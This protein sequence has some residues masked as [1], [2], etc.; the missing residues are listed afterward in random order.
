MELTF[1]PRGVLQI[2][3]ARI[4]Y[5]NFRGEAS[6]FTREGDRR[7]SLVIPDREMSEALKAEGWN[8]KEKEFEDG[9]YFAHLPVKVNINDRGPS[10]YL[11]SGNSKPVR[12]DEHTVGIIDEIDILSVNLDIRPFD[13]E[14]NGNT[15]RTA[16]LQGLEVFQDLNRFDEKYAEEEYPEE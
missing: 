15:G 3:E 11:I 13:W 10:M 12:L 4:C 16:Y 9:E 6:K 1:A 14:V 7:F 8:V 2:N 5:K